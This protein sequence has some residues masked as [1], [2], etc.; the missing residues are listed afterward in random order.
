MDIRTGSVKAE[1]KTTAFIKLD[2][3]DPGEQANT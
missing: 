2:E 1:L 3:D